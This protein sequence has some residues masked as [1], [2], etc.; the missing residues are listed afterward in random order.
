MPG[1][2]DPHLLIFSHAQLIIYLESGLVGG[3]LS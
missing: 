3:R 1:V 2:I